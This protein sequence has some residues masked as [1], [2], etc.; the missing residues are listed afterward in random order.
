VGCSD[1]RADTDLNAKGISSGNGMLTL[2]PKEFIGIRNLSVIYF[3]LKFG[4]TRWGG[5][6]SKSLHPFDRCRRSIIKDCFV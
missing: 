5:N 4:G 1:L 6:Y 3:E 2:G